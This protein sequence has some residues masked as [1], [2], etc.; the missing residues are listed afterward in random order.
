MIRFRNPFDT[1]RLTPQPVVVPAAPPQNDTYSQAVR[2]GGFV[3]LSGQLGTRPDGT[4]PDTLPA[5]VRQAL[6]NVTAVLD[7]A[8]SA[9]S[10]VTRVNIFITD[11]A[12]S[13][14]RTRSATRANPMG[15]R[16]TIGAAL[17]RSLN[18]PLTVMR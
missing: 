11:Y 16:S 3:F 18:Y 4:L 2:V 17:Y 13:A 15:S 12:K 10:L 14:I 9:L 7:A 8:G 5:Q 1:I 6:D